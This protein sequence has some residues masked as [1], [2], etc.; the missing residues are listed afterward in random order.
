MSGM[1]LTTAAAWFDRGVD[2]EEEDAEEAVAAYRAARHEL[3]HRGIGRG[4]GF[5]RVDA[6]R[7]AGGKR[8]PG[9]GRRCG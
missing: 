9:I 3:R 6:G 5:H 8:P 7:S 2:L 1:W 4:Q